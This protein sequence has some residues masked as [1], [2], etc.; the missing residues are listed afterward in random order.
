LGEVD[1]IKDYQYANA[2]NGV[3]ETQKLGSN[4]EHHAQSQA[5]IAAEWLSIS[6]LSV[7]LF[8]DRS[9]YRNFEL[10]L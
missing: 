5:R 4:L 8:V 1:V 2:G 6:M 7:F 9:A 10:G 3:V